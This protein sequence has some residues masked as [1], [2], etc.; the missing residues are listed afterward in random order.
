MIKKGSR[1]A[2]GAEALL[3]CSPH[4]AV[5]FGENQDEPN[6]YSQSLAQITP[7]GLLLSDKRVQIQIE[8]AAEHRAENCV[9]KWAWF[10][11][12]LFWVTQAHAFPPHYEEKANKRNAVF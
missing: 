3:D 8:R 4:A 9:L 2:G 6:Q 5:F 7:V 12:P 10:K 1:D 11:T